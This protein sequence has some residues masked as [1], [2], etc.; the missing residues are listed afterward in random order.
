VQ[1]GGCKKEDY[2]SKKNGR[3]QSLKEKKH[4]GETVAIN[5]KVDAFGG[6]ERGKTVSIRKT[7][8]TQ[9]LHNQRRK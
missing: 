7:T 1:R 4:L 2:Q 5:Q 9:P 8:E 6:T 3:L